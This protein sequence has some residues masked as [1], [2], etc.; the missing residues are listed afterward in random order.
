VTTRHSALQPG[1]GVDFY[2]T[3]VTLRC[4]LDYRFVPPGDRDLS[5]ARFLI[6]L[7]FAR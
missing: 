3:V 7:V 4:Q 6:G 2:T 1:M 5:A